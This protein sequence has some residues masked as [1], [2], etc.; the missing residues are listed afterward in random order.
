MKNLEHLLYQNESVKPVFTPLPLVSYRSG[1]KLSSYLV[2]IKFYHLERRRGSYN[3]GN[4]T[5]QVCKNID[6]IDTFTSTVTGESFKPNL[7][8]LFRGSF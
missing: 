8:G 3:C 5:Y 7:A 4:S 6:E 1:R 2:R